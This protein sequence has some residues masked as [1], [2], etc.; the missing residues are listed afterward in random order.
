MKIRLTSVLDIDTSKFENLNKSEF[1]KQVVGVFNSYMQQIELESSSLLA[2][3]NAESVLHR[4]KE[5][6]T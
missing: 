3:L 2:D 5:C 6:E 4:R 1:R